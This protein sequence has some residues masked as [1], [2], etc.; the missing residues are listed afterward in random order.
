MSVT[1]IVL[2]SYKN[3]N[4]Q[5]LVDNI[6]ET[7]VM[8]NFFIKI[9]DQSNIRKHFTFKDYP[10]LQYEYVHWDSI[11]SP[12]TR[13]AEEIE[14]SESQFTA[15]ISDDVWFNPG[16]DIKL[17]K[18]FRDRDVVVS[19]R[20]TARVSYKDVY[21]IA[22][23]PVPS[24]D[25]ALSQYIDRNFIFARTELLQNVTYPPKLKYYGEEEMFTINL[26]DGEIDIYNAPGDLYVDLGNRPIE[27]L[28]TTFSKYHNFNNVH[29][30]INSE[31][32]GNFLKYHNLDKD[33]YKPA[34]DLINDVQYNVHEDNFFTASAKKFVEKVNVLNPAETVV[35]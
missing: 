6:Y 9:I 17:A 35:E 18:F 5:E 19:G 11:E 32:A 25:F 31:K 15:F 29:K 34:P 14:K 21:T 22:N 30:A 20:M 10:N 4:L 3:K 23:N 7:S 28:Y 13:K 26:L 8:K 12:C 2:Y 16:W 33:Y 27:N 1:R 24:D